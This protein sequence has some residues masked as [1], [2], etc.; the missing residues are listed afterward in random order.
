[1]QQQIAKFEKYLDS[2]SKRDQ[3]ALFVTFLVV[4]MM[5]WTELIYAPL[6][7]EMTVVEQEIA[8]KTSEI[9]VFQAKTLAL[10]KSINTD[11]D[12]ENRQQLKKYLE[13]SMLLD[14]A[15]AK[16]STQIISPQEMTGL[17]EQ[18]LK[19]Q[20]GL[21]FVSLKNKPAEPEFVKSLSESEMDVEAA[22]DTEN[23]STIYRHSVV[24]QME[25]SYHDALSYL[26]TLE[27]LPWRFFWQSVEIETSAYPNTL[28]TLEVYTLGLR[29][30]LIGV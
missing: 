28:I 9:E 3:I 1:M 23:V 13:E 7:E 29:E 5:I 22:G 8:Q 14:E 27:Q 16:T 15:L 20:A 25:G 11:P 2:L 12:A 26:K 30:G 24:L 6:S 10:Q 19:S 17:M 4:V 18:I 21:K